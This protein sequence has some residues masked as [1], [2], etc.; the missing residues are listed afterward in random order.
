[1]RVEFVAFLAK[2]VAIDESCDAGVAEEYAPD[3]GQAT[4]TPF[5]GTG[6]AVALTMHSLQLDAIRYDKLPSSLHHVV[7]HYGRQTYPNLSAKQSPVSGI[8]ET[9]QFWYGHATGDHTIRNNNDRHDAK[10]ISW[11]SLNLLGPS[12]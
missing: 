6:D 8:H 4:H 7:A 12:S 5:N 11:I 9:I 3:S 10:Q 2:S 1:L